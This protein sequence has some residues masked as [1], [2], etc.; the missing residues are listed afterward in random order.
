METK[1]Y[2][3]RGTRRGNK[4]SPKK[5]R[6]EQKFKETSQIWIRFAECLKEDGI[7]LGQFR[8]IDQFEKYLWGEYLKAKKEAEDG[9]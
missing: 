6:A 1:T 9:T 4:S 8:G 7:K 5:I 3:G 2:E